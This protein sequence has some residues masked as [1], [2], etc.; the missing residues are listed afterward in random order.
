[1]RQIV[2]LICVSGLCLA[3]SPRYRNKLKVFEK[4]SDF[5]QI[6]AL[7]AIRRNRI[8]QTFHQKTTQ[9]KSNS[10]FDKETKVFLPTPSPR[11]ADEGLEIDGMSSSNKPNLETKQPDADNLFVTD[12]GK[13][14]TDDNDTY[15]FGDDLNLIDDIRNFKSSSTPKIF[16]TPSPL[17]QEGKKAARN[18][19]QR[20]E[21]DK[22][23]PQTLQSLYKSDFNNKTF[24]LSLNF[25][26]QSTNYFHPSDLYNQSLD[27]I[28]SPPTLSPETSETKDYPLTLAIKQSEGRSEGLDVDDHIA[29]E[30]LTPAFSYGSDNHYDDIEYFHPG[31]PQSL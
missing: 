13:L 3:A 12:D 21:T 23:G 2:N 26:S 25:P 27:Q 17:V 11:K 22:L 28:F 7:D 20:T 14:N 30:I 4:P 19:T 1:M 8:I 15:Y 5:E 18:E 9:S 6:T 31:K 16:V 10:D 24:K 29:N